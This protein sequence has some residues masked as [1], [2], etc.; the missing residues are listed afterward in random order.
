MGE[1]MPPLATRQNRPSKVVTSFA[2]NTTGERLLV[3]FVQTS[4][5]E[6]VGII[7]S[8]SV[9]DTREQLATLPER[10]APFLA[11]AWFVQD[12]KSLVSVSGGQGGKYIS[13]LDASF[14]DGEVPSAV[15]KLAEEVSGY[16]VASQITKAE[17]LPDITK[18]AVKIN[19]DNARDTSA[20]DQW[21]AWYLSDPK[22]RSISPFSSIQSA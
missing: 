22:T 10:S 12:G 17:R 7:S 1:E 3:G 5:G 4:A 15:W 19:E 13:F 6:N 16:D 11:D 9:W 21:L 14:S 2:L 18:S 8:L 20:F